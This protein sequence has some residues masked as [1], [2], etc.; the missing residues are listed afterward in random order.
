MLLK[1]L[2]YVICIKIGIY[3]P[4]S[5][6]FYLE[7]ASYVLT[8][9]SP[10]IVIHR[11]SGDAP[12]DL[13]VAPQWNIHKKWVMNGLDKFLKEKDLWQGKYYKKEN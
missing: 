5:L 3:F 2:F 11:I 4:I 12:K 13:L 10:D 6:E 8:H 9:I 1:I 7:S